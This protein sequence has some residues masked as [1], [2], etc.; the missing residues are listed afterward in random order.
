[1]TLARHRL[2]A[3]M[4]ETRLANFHQT[5]SIPGQWVTYTK[6]PRCCR[7]QN[8]LT[9][10]EGAVSQ[11]RLPLKN[12]GLRFI[13]ACTFCVDKIQKEVEGLATPEE[14]SCQTQSPPG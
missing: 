7:C 11:Q 8:K 13:P 10:E 6:E 9:P 14:T 5:G 3:P 2:P 12:K 1:M 4:W